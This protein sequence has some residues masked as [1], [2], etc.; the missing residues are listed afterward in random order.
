M[1]AFFDSSYMPHGHCYLWEPSILWTNVI[2]DI[3]I[4][5]SY[6]SIPLVILIFMMKRK[7]IEN[8][9][10]PVMFS[11]FI[12][13]CGV[14]HIFGVITIWHGVYGWH[15]I[16]KL[17]T[18]VVSMVTAMYIF[19]LLPT[20]LKAPSPKQV[21]N[22]N[23]ELES[24]KSRSEALES[25]LLDYSLFKFVV[26][27]IVE[28]VILLDAQNRLVLA[29]QAFKDAY[30]LTDD[31]VLKFN[32]HALFVDGGEQLF[33]QI[34]NLK[35]EQ[36]RSAKCMLNCLTNTGDEFPAA[37]YLSQ[38]EHH[39]QAMTVLNIKDLTDVYHA[40]KQLSQSHERFERILSATQDGIWEW[41][42]SKDS[43]WYSDTMRVLIGAKPFENAL[44]VSLW[45][46]HI[47][48]DFTE[49]FR[50]VFD[51]S[52]AD[53][54]PFSLEYMGLNKEGEYQWFLL[55][56]R[57][58]VNV[59]DTKVI[60]GSLSL[61]DDRKRIEA[62]LYN[63]N[64]FLETVFDGASHGLFVV[65]VDEDG[66]DNLVALNQS[67][68]KAF[69]LTFNQVRGKRLSELTLDKEGL[70]ASKLADCISQKATTQGVCQ[71]GDDMQS[72]WLQFAFHPIM[73]FS[74]NISH[75]IGAVSDIT[76]LILAEQKLEQNEYFLTNVINNAICALFTYD[77]K[78][79]SMQQ[80]NR[81]YSA[82]TGYDLSQL[83]NYD[84]LN[85]VH[86]KDKAKVDEHYARLI[87][88]NET[89]LAEIDY[90]ILH[91]DGHWIW[92]SSADCVIQRDESGNATHILCT[93]IDITDLKTSLTKLSE[94]NQ[95]LEHFAIMASH[96]L[97]EPLRKITAFSKSLL[98]RLEKD[99]DEQSTF[100]MTRVAASAERMRTMIKD[101]LA[102]ARM[103]DIKPNLVSIKVST[104]VEHACD[105]LER[106][107]TSKKAS[108]TCTTEAR[109]EVDE[110]LFIQLFQNL[111]HNAIKFAKEGETP[112][113][114]IS[115]EH[116]HGYLAIHIKDNG[117]GFDATQADA[118][119]EPF[120]RLVAKEEYS[121][122]G[123]GLAM[124]R[125]IA[126][127]HHAK[128][129]ATSKLNEGSTFTIL[130]PK[131]TQ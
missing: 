19:Y 4:A 54:K 30:Q 40:E 56:G 122:K 95:M 110:S 82:I 117:I 105:A 103:K 1:S 70:L 124:C 48:G 52:I 107:I 123:I 93:F 126:N 37:I 91:A 80:I 17:I 18:A 120:K 108:V 47:H 8:R 121:G 102:L 15:G 16:M 131:V 29:N 23:L 20:I 98:A 66:T 5:A 60:S 106:L 21:E 42:L 86:P 118:I 97:Q 109:C 76:S 53:Q 72:S 14:T 38:E 22:L 7:D 9:I 81:R 129:T 65:D 112:E 26:N 25:E 27:G 127:I 59:N 32:L 45:E 100:E 11:L 62:S 116:S 24:E 74:G 84:H 89:S 64:Q 83:E 33:A 2:S 90:R 6:F 46:S 28:P 55:R 58:T 39:G 10:V 85:F 36:A 44:G 35:H 49:E 41:D 31:Q 77:V 13:S 115:A 43:A 101:V 99:L 63:K 73:D 128:I 92:C 130:L 69:K 111:I 104:L 119:F 88:E 96:D 113:I 125:Q 50:M 78:N 75:V 34:T 114:T 79:Q 68:E 61:I 71:F 87:E 67:A 12:F 3:V 51:Q 57:V 94:S